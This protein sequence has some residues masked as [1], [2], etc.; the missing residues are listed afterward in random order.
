MILFSKGIPFALE[1]FL[2]GVD[3]CRILSGVSRAK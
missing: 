2:M 3:F 1:L